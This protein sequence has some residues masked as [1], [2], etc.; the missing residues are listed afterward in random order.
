VL[1]ARQL[2]TSMKAPTLKAL[3]VGDNG[4]KR[5]RKAVDLLCHRS[6]VIVLEV[7]EKKPFGWAKVNSNSNKT[8]PNRNVAASA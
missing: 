8:E 1:D 2:A 4:K 6:S 3:V 5:E 7:V